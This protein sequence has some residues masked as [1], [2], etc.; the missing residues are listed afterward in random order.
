MLQTQHQL[1]LW[2]GKSSLSKSCTG[3]KTTRGFPYTVILFWLQFTKQKKFPIYQSLGMWSQWNFAQ[4]MPV[5]L[6]WYL[7]NFIVTSWFKSH[8]LRISNKKR[9]SWVFSKTLSR[10][11][12]SGMLKGPKLSATHFTYCYG[13]THS[14]NKP[15][16]WCMHRVS[17]TKTHQLNS[18]R[19]GSNHSSELNCNLPYIHEKIMHYMEHNIV[20]IHWPMGDVA[21]IVN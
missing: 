5:L 12:S 6:L 8:Q 18:D 3:H 13:Q 7:Q 14:L 11:P 17:V 21:L 1:F 16:D 19:G 15:H 10:F 20:L 4:A 9:M 2:P